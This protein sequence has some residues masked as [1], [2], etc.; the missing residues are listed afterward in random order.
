MSES[1]LTSVKKVLGIAEDYTEF[2]AD[3][4]MHINSILGTLTQIGIGPEGGYAITGA[5]ETWFDFV[6]NNP[7]FKMVQSYVYIRVRLLFDPPAT[8]Y[9]IAAF[10]KNAEE[11]FG[12]LSITREEL[13]WEPE[14]VEIEDG[15]LDGGSP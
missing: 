15:I 6:G 2:D 14:E 9:L 5:T 13:L 12:R 11:L 7:K 3:V 10:E 1:I 4:T 8:S